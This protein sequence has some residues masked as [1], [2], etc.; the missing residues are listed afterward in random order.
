MAHSRL[1]IKPLII[2]FID[3][4]EDIRD[5]YQ[6]YTQAEMQKLRSAGYHHSFTSLEDG[7]GDYVA[8]YL[9]ASAYLKTF[10]TGHLML[11]QFRLTNA[12]L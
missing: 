8:H 12:L 6:Y 10:V 1:C 3:T 2:E 11:A 9:S 7:I 5:T 4:P